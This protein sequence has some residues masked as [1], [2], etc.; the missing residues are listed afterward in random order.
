MN[1]SA[2][3]CWRCFIVSIALILL[4]SFFPAPIAAAMTGNPSLTAEAARALVLPL[5]SANAQMG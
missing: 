2:A 4:S 3:K 5:G 1:L